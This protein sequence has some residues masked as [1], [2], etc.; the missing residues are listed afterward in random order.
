MVSIIEERQPPSLWMLCG[1]EAALC[2]WKRLMKSTRESVGVSTSQQCNSS[3]SP[4]TCSEAP[5]LSCSGWRSLN[6]LQI[7]LIFPGPGPFRVLPGMMTVAVVLGV[8]PY[9]LPHYLAIA[10]TE[11]CKRFNQTSR[12]PCAARNKKE[13]FAL[14]WKHQRD[15]APRTSEKDNPT[16]RLLSRP[17]VNLLFSIYLCREKRTPFNGTQ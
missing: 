2:G 12:L 1:S 17:E 8:F 5:L 16:V 7:S 11:A 9:F 3:C 13:S 10:T 4:C 14:W 6:D 15:P